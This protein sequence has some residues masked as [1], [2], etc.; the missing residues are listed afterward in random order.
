MHLYTI[1]QFP[2]TERN[3]DNVLCDIQYSQYGDL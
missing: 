2:Q 3:I 1:P